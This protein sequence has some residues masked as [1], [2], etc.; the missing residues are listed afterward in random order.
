MTY[1]ELKKQRDDLLAVLRKTLEHAVG[2]ACD[3]RGISPAE[4]DEWPWVQEAQ[5]AVD[6]AGGAE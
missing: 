4:C 1:D 6:K 2:H 3:A 5:A